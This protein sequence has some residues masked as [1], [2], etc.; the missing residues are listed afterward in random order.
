ML[1][2]ARGAATYITV[3]RITAQAL[4]VIVSAIA[5]AA[6]VV[7]LAPGAAGATRELL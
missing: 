1:D 2:D 6:L 3:L 4:A 5:A 7:R